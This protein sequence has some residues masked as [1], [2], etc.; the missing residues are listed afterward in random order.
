MG[1]FVEIADF[2]NIFLGFLVRIGKP[3][4]FLF[5]GIF[6]VIAD[7]Q[8]FFLNSGANSSLIL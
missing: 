6:V 8:I 3:R 4:F 1:I 5:Y 2:K 7:F